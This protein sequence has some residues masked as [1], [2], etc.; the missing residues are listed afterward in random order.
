M[1]TLPIAAIALLLTACGGVPAELRAPRLTPTDVA[2][3]KA[4]IGDDATSDKARPPGSR[5]V[6]HE[7]TLPVCAPRQ[8]RCVGSHEVDRMSET[9][10]DELRGTFR[11]RNAVAVTIGKVTGAGLALRPSAAVG[12]VRQHFQYPGGVTIVE[13]S[14]PV[15]A[16]RDAALVYVRYDCGPICGTCWFVRLK[17]SARGAWEVASQ[18][19]LSIS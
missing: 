3:F 2:V 11:L 7:R 5:L 12:E 18:R 14:L 4:V 19:M 1:R 6:V 15:Y 8:D 17:R 16:S 9:G 10:F 13:F